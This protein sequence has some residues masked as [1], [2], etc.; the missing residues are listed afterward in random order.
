M[1]VGSS[2]TAPTISHGV[3]G[4]LEFAGGARRAG[5]TSHRPPT[6]L[7]PARTGNDLGDPEPTRVVGSL[8]TAHGDYAVEDD[9]VVLI[10]WSNGVR[11]TIE[12]G[13]WQP[14]LDGVEADTELYGTS[15]YDRIW[16]QFT[17][18]TPAPA[19]YIHCSLPMYAAQM[20]DFLHCTATG[21]TPIAS[22]QVGLTALQVVQTAYASARQNR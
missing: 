16:P 7:R 15:G 11:S 1:V 3:A 5:G 8:S 14:R 13:W 12:F 10:D 21:A 2:P 19:D 9:G 4:R 22:A 20:A 6:G 18:N 17:P